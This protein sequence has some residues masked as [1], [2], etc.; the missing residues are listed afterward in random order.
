VA[1]VPFQEQEPV[2]FTQRGVEAEKEVAAVA[3]ADSSNK[4]VDVA[5]EVL[6][7]NQAERHGSAKVVTDLPRKTSSI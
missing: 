1:L 5:A 2:T 6:C 7:F 3:R 4:E